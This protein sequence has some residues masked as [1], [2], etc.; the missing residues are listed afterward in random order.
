M[1]IKTLRQEPALAGAASPADTPAFTSGTLAALVA[2]AAITPL[3]L[4]VAPAVAGQLG[5]QLGL[6]ASRIGTYFFVELGAFSAATLPSYLWLGRIDAR[7]IAWGATAVFCAGNL[8]T[9]V[10]MPGFAPLLALRAA[11]ALGGGTLMVLCMTS[12]AASGNSDRVY[13]LWV[14]GQLIAGAAGLFLLPHL[15]DMVGLRALYAVLAALALCAAPLARRFPAVP[16]VRAQ[17][18]PRARAQ[19]VRMAA[20]LAIGGV[21]TFYVA[22]GGVWTFASKAASAVGLDAQTSGNVLA[23]ASLMGI[24]G[25]ALASYLGGRAARRAML[26][27]G[28]GILAASLVALAAAPNANG[29]TLAIFGFKFAWTFVLPFMLAS[30]AAVDATGRLIATLNLVIGSGL[31][32]GPLAAGLMLDGGGT[33]RALFSIAAAVSL[34]SLAAMLRVER[35]AR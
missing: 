17:H 16:R 5:A 35:D 23:I 2:F 12:A 20:A 6:S 28:Y 7:R 19:A 30:V 21:L 22:I 10:W 33:L 18:A 26:L 9:A 13:G 24:A 29:Y 27:A 1:T 11:T 15:F 31:A 25:A 14:V 34:V 8:A 4:L 32:A 3:L